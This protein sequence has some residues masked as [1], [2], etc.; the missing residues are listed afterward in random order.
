[1]DDTLRRGSMRAVWAQGHDKVALR[2]LELAAREN[3]GVG[4]APR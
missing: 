2:P 4:T 3:R 1:M